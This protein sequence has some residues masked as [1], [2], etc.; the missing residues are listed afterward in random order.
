MTKDSIILI[1]SF[2]SG[3]ILG[4][5]L[6]FVLFPDM[7]KKLRSK[8]WWFSRYS[9]VKERMR[10]KVFMWVQVILWGIMTMAVWFIFYCVGLA[11]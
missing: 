4:W 10:F 5:I 7:R 6:D 3:W 11:D 8:N 1:I 9:D 2:G